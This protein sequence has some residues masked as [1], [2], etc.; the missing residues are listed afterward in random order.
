MNQ[1]WQ[2]VLDTNKQHWNNLGDKEYWQKLGEQNGSDGFGID[3]ASALLSGVTGVL[4]SS[5]N[6]AQINDTSEYDNRI[7]DLSQIGYADYDNF[8]AL[9]QAYADAASIDTSADYDKIRGMSG[10]QAAGNLIENTMTGA[11]TGLT[12]GG[13]FGAIA[14][15]V[16]GFGSGLAGLISGD[17]KARAEKERIENEGTIAANRTRMGLQYQ[18]DNLSSNYFHGRVGYALAKGGQIERRQMSIQEFADK[19]MSQPKD[20]RPRSSGFTRVHCNGGTMI[21]FKG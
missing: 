19:I 1:Y 4:S 2:K 16:I 20:Y 6:A 14:G 8:D 13:P 9:N 12:V 17:K 15:G 18:H 10:G 7:A 21:R 11:T 5:M 3:K